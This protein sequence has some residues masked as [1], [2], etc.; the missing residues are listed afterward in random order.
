MLKN[1]NRSAKIKCVKAVRYTQS[2]NRATDSR[3]RELLKQAGGYNPFA[4]RPII[5][6]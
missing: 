1:G 3:V 6:Y 4:F 5:K 2:A